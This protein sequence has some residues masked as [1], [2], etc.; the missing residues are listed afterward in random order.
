MYSSVRRL[1]VTLGA[2]M[3]LGVGAPAA[4]AQATVTQTTTISQDTDN[5]G[6]GF[7]IKG[8]PLFSSLSSDAV[9]SPLDTRTGW[10]GGLF[11]G[12]NRKGVVGVGVDVL[13][14]RKNVSTPTGDTNLDYLEV[15]IYLRINIGAS[16]ASGARLYAV[17][18]PVFDVRLKGEL[19]FDTSIPKQTEGVDV[20]IQ[21]GAGV[22]FARLMIE[23]RYTKGLRDIGKELTLGQK[24]TTQ[25]FAIMVGLRLN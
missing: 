19:Q 4:F 1:T 9:T 8:G 12:G 10:I 23:G 6:I 14:A 16:S 17:A 15:P 7:G 25:S 24:I 3:V 21:G 2:A 11:I 20:G 13:Y 22:E 5:G 18:G